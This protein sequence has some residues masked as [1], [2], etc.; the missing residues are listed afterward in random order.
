MLLQRDISTI[1]SADREINWQRL[2]WT[3]LVIDDPVNTSVSACRGF[4]QSSERLNVPALTESFITLLEETSPSCKKFISSLTHYLF[5][6]LNLLLRWTLFCYSCW[7]VPCF[8]QQ[9]HIPWRTSKY[10]LSFPTYN[11]LTENYF[12]TDQVWSKRHR[13]TNASSFRTFSI[14]NYSNLLMFLVD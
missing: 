3:S 6:R 5:F 7:F 12:W 4:V 9:M 14:S 10:V 1:N 11:L 2:L 8:G 13:Q